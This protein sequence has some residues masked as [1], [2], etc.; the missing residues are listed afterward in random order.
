MTSAVRRGTKLLVV[1]IGLFMGT[2]ACAPVY[3]P[4]AA[5]IPMLDKQGSLHAGL[6]TGTPGVQA[7]F[8]YGVT[9][10]FMAK[11][12]VQ[13]VNGKATYYRLINGGG[14]VYWSTLDP[15]DAGGVRTSL[16]GDVGGGVA[17]GESNTTGDNTLVYSGAFGRASFQGDIGY[18]VRGFNAGL[19]ARFV[20]VH[21]EHDKES[22]ASGETAEW[23]LAEPLFILRLGHPQF[24]AE[25]QVGAMIPAAGG[26]SLG[27]PF[28]FII[29]FGVT[30]DF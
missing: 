16:T 25:A 26:G 20:F 15:E 29:A 3:H 11:G 12:T 18:E 28:P 4:G 14:G 19:G 17:R 27:I 2:A 22:D 1:A 13:N 30:A 9:D 6:Y 21:F 5:H 24:K 23:I 10:R 8:A 7:N